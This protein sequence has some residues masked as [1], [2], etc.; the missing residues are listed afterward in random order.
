MSV[1]LKDVKY[2]LHQLFKNPGFTIVAMVSLALGIGVNTAIFS[3]LNAVWMRSLPVKNP[4]ELRIV[5][6]SGHNTRLSYYTGGAAD[7]GRQRSGAQCYGSF[8]YPLYQDFKEQVKGCSNVFAF[9]ELF[10]L[11]MV[12][13]QG[14]TTTDA[15]MVSGDF[16][17]GYGARALIG[18]TLGPG[19]ESSQVDP[20]AVITYRL[21]E[22]EFNLD[23]GVIGQMIILNGHQFTIVGVMPR[24]YCGPQ[25]GDMAQIYVPMSAQPLLHQHHPLDARN[26]WWVNIMVRLEPRADESQV[27]AAMEGLFLQTLSAPGQDSQADDPHIILVDGSRGLLAIRKQMAMGFAILMA[28]VGLVL[29]IA[30]ANLAGLLLARGAARRQ[31]LTIRAAMGAGRGRLIRQLLTES[32]VL[33]LVGAGL[34]LLVAMWIKAIVIGFMPTSLDNFHIDLGI[35][36]WVLLFTL[37]AAL[38]TCLLFGLLPAI[39]VTRIDLCSNLKG[40]KCLGTHGLR[41][42]KVLVAAQVSLAVLLVVGAGLLMQTLINLYRTDLGFS[43]DKILVFGV[44]P[45]QAGFKD[46]NSVRLYDQIQANIADLPGV[47]SVALSSDSLLGGR[48]ASNG[49]SIPGRSQQENQHMQADVLDVSETFFQTMGIP[50]LRGRA[51][52][53]TD[54]PSGPRVVI[55][56][57]T[58]VRTYFSNEDPLGQSIR[59]GNR[60]FQIVGLCGDAKYNRIQRDIEPILYFSHRQAASGSMFFEVRT[61]GNPLALVPAVRKIVA[62]LDRTIP[63]ENVSTQLQLL[64]NSITSERIFT[65]LCGGLAILGILLSCIGLY[66]LLAFMVTRRTGEIGVRLALGARPRD[67]AWPIIRNALW[68]AGF[69]LIIGIPVALVFVRLLRSFL[70]GVKPH[71]PMTIMA[72]ILLV[73][74]V[75]ALAAWI[76]ARRAAKVDPMEAL[77]YE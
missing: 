34:G 43:T 21:W 28:A 37:G 54:T 23:P 59:I 48:R 11:T 74:S 25:I 5:N 50:L 51:F 17:E 68:L 52:E 70:Y 77:R 39:C 22:K 8:P 67:I 45:G 42:G 33:S 73:L 7:G 32:M 46:A 13:S 60:D 75:A 9:F 36:H 56:N 62:D 61:A 30:C 66:G 76:P 18:R 72:S 65:S 47:R 14:A 26:H 10:G 19:D 31:E 35:D 44:N 38:V 15:L 55:A 27:V 64:K 71:D 69:G 29:M 49:F 63:L 57:E 41:L 12:D 58:L 4:H 24:A 16:F 40:Q 20:V 6:W 3:L 1:F 53:R 2:T